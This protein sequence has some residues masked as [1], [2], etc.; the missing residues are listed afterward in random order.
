M[1]ASGHGGRIWWSGKRGDF[2]CD[3]AT[4]RPECFFCDVGVRLE[5]ERDWLCDHGEGEDDSEGLRV[6]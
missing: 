3:F 2:Q 6:A 5:I 4:K 1:L